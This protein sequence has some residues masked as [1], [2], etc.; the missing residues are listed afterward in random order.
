MGL[1]K[2][3]HY[4][5]ELRLTLPT[6]YAAIRNLYL[7]GDEVVADFAIQASRE[8]ALDKTVKPLAVV[9]VRFPY[10]RGDDLVKTAYNFAK[11]EEVV[12]RG[13]TT[14]HHP[15]PLFGWTDDIH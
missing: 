4:I 13:K 7:N 3:N 15:R 9:S 1:K 5:E 8:L 10:V 12:T 2:T 14:T 11:G 6:A